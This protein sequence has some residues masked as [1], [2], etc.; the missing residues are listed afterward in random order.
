MKRV[1]Y[2]SVLVFDRSQSK[3]LMVR[4]GSEA[5]SYW[6]LPTGG[7]EK[8]ET[9]EQAAVREAKEETGL[10]I[11]ITGLYTVRE[12]FFSTRGEHALLFTFYAKVT[13]G[14]LQISDPDQEIM[15][16]C[17][18]EIDRANELMTYLPEKVKI[19]SGGNAESN[20]AGIYYF[21]GEEA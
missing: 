6:S 17:W 13:G 18:M 11:E 9:L 3:V 12:V 15:E 8:G 4:N 20:P 10:D 1:D 5:S 7:V 16:A 2:A 21:H 19:K 14:Q